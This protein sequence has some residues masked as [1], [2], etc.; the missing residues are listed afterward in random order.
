MSIWKRKK[1]DTEIKP[2]GSVSPIGSSF[3]MGAKII[4]INAEQRTS[5]KYYKNCEQLIILYEGKVIVEA[6][7]EKEF[8]DFHNEGRNYFE[9]SPG[10]S[11]LVQAGNP[12]R[13]SALQNSVLIEV[14]GGRRYSINETND[15]VMLEDDYGRA[16]ISNNIT[17]E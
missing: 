1:V 15:V 11:L 5:L 17:G 9:L 6:P 8:G 13:I 14:V 4:K 2:W 7:D 3:A 10:E 12:Y 16:T